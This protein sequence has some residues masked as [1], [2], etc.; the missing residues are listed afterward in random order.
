M[1]ARIP[2]TQIADLPPRSQIEIRRN[3]EELAN[4]IVSNRSVFDA[5]IDGALATSSPS[6]HAYKNITDML[7]NETLSSTGNFVCGV[8]NRGPASAPI[9]TGNLVFTGSCSFIAEPGALGWTWTSSP[10][11]PGSLCLMDIRGTIDSKYALNFSGIEIKKGGGAGATNPLIDSNP[12]GRVG[13]FNCVVNGATNGSGGSIQGLCNGGAIYAVNTHFSECY[14]TV[15]TGTTLMFNCFITG[16]TGID[17]A[18]PG[19]L[20][21]D[22]G[23]ITPSAANN[24]ITITQAKTWVR[25]LL[26]PP[27]LGGTS[28]GLAWVVN[29]GSG[30]HATIHMD[31]GVNSASVSVSAASGPTHISGNAW[32]AVTFSGNNS[33]VERTFQ[34]VCAGPNLDITGPARITATV[35]SV[36]GNNKAIFRGN[37]I[38]AD[39]TIRGGANPYIALI[40]CTNSVIKAAL[41]TPGSAGAQAYTIDAASSKC[42]LLIAGD[43]HA[44]FSVASTNAGTNCLVTDE[45][46]APP[47]GAAGGDLTGSTYPNPLVAGIAA[48]S[49]DIKI[50]TAGKGFYVKEG[51]NATMGVATLV[52]GTVVVATTKVTANSRIQLTAQVLGTV[53]VPKAIAVTARTAA[54]SFTITSA[55]ATDT[56]TVAWQIV[57]PA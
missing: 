27:Q 9:D 34:G 32:A 11:L 21:W 38:V 22:G 29:T 50:G 8:I 26:Q 20:Y 43:T 55:D 28:G 42:V 41:V 48:A 10:M 51:A 53:T 19:D 3:F 7:A 25:I 56:S 18:P 23:G 44:N 14:P 40:A 36:Q 37:G 54:T 57:E 2:F 1:T 4:S 33:L 5:V 45:M 17:W 12:F 52:A 46:G 6:T 47:T 15:T 13:L 16:R 39:M 30:G 24:T 35:T 31:S 49:L